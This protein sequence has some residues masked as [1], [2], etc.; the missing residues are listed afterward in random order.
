MRAV[1]GIPLQNSR[2]N[3]LYLST[4]VVAFFTTT[5]FSDPLLLFRD[6]MSCS[7]VSAMSSP[8]SLPSVT[9]I[10][11]ITAPLPS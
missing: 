7:P 3:Y 11:F 8:N 4:H 1:L 2:F 10:H 9:I 5:G 6:N